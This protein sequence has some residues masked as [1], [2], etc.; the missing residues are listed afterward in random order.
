MRASRERPFDTEQVFDGD[1]SDELDDVLS[2]PHGWY[3]LV[4]LSQQ[5]GPVDLAELSRGVVGLISDRPPDDV[6]ADVVRRVQTWLHHGQLPA[7]DEFGVLRFDAESGTVSLRD[8]SVSG[9]NGPP[10]IV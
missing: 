2:D 7:R 4:Y 5:E 1:G 10:P 9:D 3:T 8:R 6:D